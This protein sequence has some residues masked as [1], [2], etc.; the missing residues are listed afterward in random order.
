M[1]LYDSCMH[2]F[3]MLRTPI[4]GLCNA[5]TKTHVSYLRG[6]EEEKEHNLQ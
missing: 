2:A 3:Q 6:E 1:R 5:H 4:S